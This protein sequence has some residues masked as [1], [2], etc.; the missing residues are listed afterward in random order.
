MHGSLGRVSVESDDLQRMRSWMKAW[1]ATPPKKESFEV[2]SGQ[3]AY[4][5]SC[6]QIGGDW[7]TAS[8]GDLL[9][10]F[11]GFIAPDELA[12]EAAAPPQTASQT[13]N[14]L[15]Q[16]YRRKGAEAL[17]ALNGRYVAC[18]W[19][20]TS[21]TLELMN[22]IL[23]YRPTFLWREAGSFAFSSSVWALAV[24]TAFRKQIDPRGLVDLLLLGHQQGNR[25]LFE[26]VE[27]LRPG[28]VTRVR[29]GRVEFQSV[30]NLLFSDDRWHWSVG[31]VAEEM[32]RLLEQSIQRYIHD[33]MAVQLP[34]SGGL[35][36]R[37]LLGFLCQRPVKV[38]AVTQYPRGFLPEDVASE[39]RYA[40][41][42]ARAAGV[43][44]KVVPYRHNV[45]DTY[46]ERC[47][48]ISGG[49]YDTH[50]CRFLSLL[51]AA[52]FG[53]IPTVTAHLGGELT[54]RF[55]I[56][57][58]QFSSTEEHF[59]L[60]LG[61]LNY[62]PLA[63]ATV[64]AMTRATLGDG[65]VEQALDECTALMASHKGPFFH[66]HFV[67]DLMLRRRRYISY[68][69]HFIDQFSDTIA[70]FY[71]RDF[72]DFICSLPFAAIE[73]QRA[74]C[75][76]QRQHFPLLSRIPNTTTGAPVLSSTL[77]TVKDCLRNQVRRARRYIPF[78]KS[79][80]ELG[81]YLSGGSK[82]VLDHLLRNADMYSSYLEP[83]AVKEAVARHLAGDM[84]QSMG[85]L[86]LS[87]FVTALDMLDDPYAA[88]RAWAGS[89][90]QEGVG[91]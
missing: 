46:R 20:L 38:Y 91:S 30:R 78:R 24:H 69:L 52:P 60:A 40:R 66:Q 18:V 73:E 86:A 9:L 44:H 10:V 13:A 48:A 51:D 89:D 8:D 27:L 87:A 58:T 59:R 47:V 65:L 42:A 14:A 56:A 5:A 12:G 63:P 84:S 31:H 71:D 79:P 77:A 2:N 74:Y 57:E 85:L 61:Q 41:R 82:P 34:L 7:P 16:L 33:G 72:V 39:A 64:T 45:F 35:D 62:F 17:A 55:Q 32:Y 28:G 6:K 37:V 81:F 54:S 26:D 49:M 23:G 43:E 36:S 88:I 80:E 29:D 68:M 53:H 21:K 22:D 4:L 25:T 11:S 76:M 70:P 15:L 67:W 83:E 50:T 19:N 75:A 90:A 1:I 3:F